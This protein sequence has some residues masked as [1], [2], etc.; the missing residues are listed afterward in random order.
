[1]KSLVQHARQSVEGGALG[2]E[3]RKVAISE[4]CR[5]AMFFLSLCQRLLQPLD[6]DCSIELSIAYGCVGNASQ[7]HRIDDERLHR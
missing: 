5:P 1:M 6:D 2:R 4:K 7:R 3:F